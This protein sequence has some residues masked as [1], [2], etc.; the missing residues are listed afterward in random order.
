[1]SE[2]RVKFDE[3]GQNLIARIDLPS[4]NGPIT[5]KA[6]TPMIRIREEVK[7]FLAAHKETIG[8]DLTVTQN[9][10]EITRRAA[11]RRLIRKLH[12]HVGAWPGGHRTE[13]INTAANQLLSDARAGGVPQR[14]AQ[15]KLYIIATE[16]KRGE[17]S[18]VIAMAALRRVNKN[19]EKQDN[20]TGRMDN[21]MGLD[22]GDEM[23]GGI[24]SFL[25]KAAKGTAKVA[26]V[27]TDTIVTQNPLAKT[28]ISQVPGGAA[29]LSAA[30][31]ARNLKKVVTS[32]K[33]GNPTAKKSIEELKAEA[34]RGNKQAQD[35]LL[36]MQKA[37]Q[38][39]KNGKKPS[40]YR[41]AVRLGI[42]PMV[43][44]ASA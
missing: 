3:E 23:V 22:I 44:E 42:N 14:T 1:M 37:N 28:L 41:R 40:L 19:N 21:T 4:P 34:A 6:E 33:S 30:D 9:I 10:P 31:Y 35:A 24:K 15:R 12:D 32:A 38:D 43:W 8:G 27:T 26:A 7:R 2:F 29:A 20:E 11:K 16:A 5:V 18:A 13:S 17:P 25:K 36:A 39:L